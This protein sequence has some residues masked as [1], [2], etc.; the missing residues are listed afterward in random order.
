MP[1]AARGLF[2]KN[3]APWTVKHPQK[4]LIIKN[5][6]KKNLDF[7]LPLCYIKKEFIA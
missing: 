7:C 5:G 4:L 2:L 3:T 1:P 6:D